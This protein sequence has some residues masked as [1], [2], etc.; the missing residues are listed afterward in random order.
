M[1]VLFGMISASSLCRMSRAPYLRG[2]ECRLTR[3]GEAIY[4]TL[5]LPNATLPPPTTHRTPHPHTTP[6]TPTTHYTPYT[7]QTP[8]PIPHT[9]YP[10]PHTPHLVDRGDEG[11]QEEGRD[12]SAADVGYI[13]VI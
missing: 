12:D 10:I 3:K 2:D 8:Y 1:A 11:R 5:L 6:Y 4:A 9:S 7:D 13:G